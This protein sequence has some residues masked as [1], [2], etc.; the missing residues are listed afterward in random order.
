MITLN[1]I[2]LLNSSNTHDLHKRTPEPSDLFFTSHHLISYSFR[3]LTIFMIF[4]ISLTIS[5]SSFTFPLPEN[6]RHNQ[7]AFVATTLLNLTNF[8]RLLQCWPENSNSVENSKNVEN[9]GIH[10]DEFLSVF[11]VILRYFVG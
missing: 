5:G 7:E 6:L 10:S 4:T 8:P 2:K 3:V 11:K 9:A 1:Y